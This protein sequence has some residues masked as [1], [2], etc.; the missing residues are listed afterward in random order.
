MRLKYP[1]GGQQSN[2]HSQGVP[3]DFLWNFQ[4]CPGGFLQNFH[5]FPGIHTYTE[6]C[7]YGSLENHGNFAPH[8]HIVRYYTSIDQNQFSHWPYFRKKVIKAQESSS[9]TH[10]HFIMC[11]TW[12][13][14]SVVEKWGRLPHQMQ[15]AFSLPHPPPITSLIDAPPLHYGNKNVTALQ[16]QILMS[17]KCASEHN[18]CPGNPGSSVCF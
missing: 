6:L 7:M 15:Y 9:C 11:S 2:E 13:F 5:G 16:G 18:F 8:V 14:I 1:Q 10:P 3:E 12:N 17:G 4:G